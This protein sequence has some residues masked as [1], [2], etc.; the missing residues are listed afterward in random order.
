MPGPVPDQALVATGHQ[1]DRL[2]QLGIPSHRAV[3]RAIQAHDL[4]QHV[5]IPGIRFR[6]RTR[7]PL[8]VTGHRH[9][10]DREHLI[11]SR[12]QRRHPRT[13]V[14]LDTDLHPRRS[15]TRLE[16]GPLIREKLPDQR[17]KTSDPIQ[18]FQ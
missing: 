16:L 13:A 17:M 14:G 7:V 6:P 4:G 12:D 1:L 15:L 18:P 11:T 5:R 3:M 8:P 10:I 9:R 2:T